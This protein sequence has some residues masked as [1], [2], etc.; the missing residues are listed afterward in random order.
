MSISFSEEQWARVRETYGSFWNKTIDRPVAGVAVKERMP[1]REDPGIDSLTQA[2]CANF[3]I[4]TDQIA[5]KIV[6]DLSQYEFYGDS[7]PVVNMDC[8][9][10]GVLAAFL[11]AKL[12]NST[13]NVWFH[14]QREFSVTDMKLEYDPDNIWIKRIKEIYAKTLDR[15]EGNVIMAV[16]DLG[17]I[18]DIVSIFL[19][20]EQ[21]L[22]DLIDEPDSVKRV[23]E[24][25]AK[26]WKQIYFELYDFLK[27]ISKGNSNWSRIYSNSEKSSYIIQCDFSYMIGTDMF[28]E[29]ALK[30]LAEQT[31]YLDN[32]I[33]HLD[34]PGELNHVDSLLG[35]ELL[36]AVQWI[37]GTGNPP[38]EEYVDLY[39]KILGAGKQVML[40]DG[41]LKTMNWIK[42]QMGQNGGLLHP[43]INCTPDEKEEQLSGLKNLGI[44]L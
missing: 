41:G 12:D 1:D 6:Y 5:D 24:D 3:S 22:F 31:E 43:L 33:Y 20:G 44:E 28:D 40:Q 17:G 38:T 34:G 25:I 7:Y 4:T 37:P 8:F 36:D 27:P 23:T 2:N 21:L 35:I 32:S 42:S 18:L 9:G 29:F 15:A 13:G 39:R 11:G 26:L 10:P 16:P 14:P 30:T 19:P